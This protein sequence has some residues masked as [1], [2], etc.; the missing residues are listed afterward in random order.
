MTDF[1]AVTGNH[2][3]D[4]LGPFVWE[5]TFDVA[6]PKET[7]AFY[8]N[9]SRFKGISSLEFL[10]IQDIPSDY[11]PVFGDSFGVV[12][13]PYDFQIKKTS[14]IH[15]VKVNTLLEIY[16]KDTSHYSALAFLSRFKGRHPGARLVK[17]V[18]VDR[19]ELEALVND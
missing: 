2:S 3:E 12:I 6:G 19:S 16:V 10:R 15:H 7:L 17:L 14:P 11:K 8:D 4:E 18:S 13:G 1:F 9:L 5:R